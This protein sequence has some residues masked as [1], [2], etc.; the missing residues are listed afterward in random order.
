MNVRT[1]RS[2]FTGAVLTGGSSSRMGT[3]KALLE[4]AGRP[5]ATYG[6]DALRGAGAAAGAGGGG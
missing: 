2:P 1:E 4:V 5:L 3:D 6:R